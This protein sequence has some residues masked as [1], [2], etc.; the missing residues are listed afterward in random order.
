MLVP[1]YWRSVGFEVS[2]AVPINNVVFWNVVQFGI[3]RTDISEICAACMFTVERILELGTALAE[4]SIL[5]SFAQ[6]TIS[7]IAVRRIL[8]LTISAHLP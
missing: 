3:V 8:N 5:Q 7:I 2:N 1:A 6:E 4:T